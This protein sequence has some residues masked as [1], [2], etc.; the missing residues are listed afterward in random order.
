MDL[1]EAAMDKVGKHYTKMLKALFKDEDDPIGMILALNE[2]HFVMLEENF[3]LAR[4]SLSSSQL[5]SLLLLVIQRQQSGL[6]DITT[7]VLSNIYKEK[8]NDE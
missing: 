6:T 8:Q 1:T 5:K 2:Y 3:D 7:D 4:E